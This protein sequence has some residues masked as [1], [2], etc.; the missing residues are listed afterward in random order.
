VTFYKS[1]DQI[2]G[3][4]DYSMQGKTYRYFKGKPLYPF[5]YGL[6]FTTFEYSNLKVNR[7]KIKSADTLN[8]SFNVANIG[9]VDGDEVCQLYVR[10]AESTLPMPIKQLKGF[11]RVHLKTGES[12]SIT[13]KLKADEDLT[14]YDVKKCGYAIE[15]GDFEIQ[16]GPSS[17]DIR[18]RETIIV[19]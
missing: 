15:P 17:Q 1:I 16:V 9:K 14:Y 8:I 19:N 13:M 7:K 5:G 11:E 6:S 18:L 4:E 3:F 12:K 10:D 2:G